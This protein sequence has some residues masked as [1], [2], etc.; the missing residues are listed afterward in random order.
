MTAKSQRDPIRVLH[1]ALRSGDD[2]LSDLLLRLLGW[3]EG[4]ATTPLAARTY[5]RLASSIGIA[6]T[7]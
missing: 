5:V 1:F 7:H 4:D 3:D 6:P 2:E